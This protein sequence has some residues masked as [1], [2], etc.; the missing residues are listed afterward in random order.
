MSRN[1][2]LVAQALAALLALLGTASCGAPATSARFGHPYLA[3]LA[4]PPE[5]ALSSPVSLG[6][7]NTASLGNSPMAAVAG[8]RASEQDKP[9]LISTTPLGEAQ[10]TVAR[11]EMLDAARRLLGIERSF[12]DRSFLGHLLRVNALLPRGVA[13]ASYTPKDYLAWARE[14][15]R[16][17]PVEGAQ[18][19]DLVLFECPGQCGVVAEDLAS[20]VVESSSQGKITWI[21]YVQG[22]VQRCVNGPSGDEMLF[23]AG[24]KAAVSCCDADQP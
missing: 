7:T 6:R 10:P 18:P 23:V 20:G 4:V 15:G 3:P 22:R 1:Q 16:E 8:A 12:D 9:P 19:G 5:H 2:P 11:T 21:A 13:A 14:Q 24:V 17:T